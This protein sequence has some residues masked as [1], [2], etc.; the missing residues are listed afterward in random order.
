[1]TGTV[2]KPYAFREGRRHRSGIAPLLWR[3]S[4]GE[5]RT[6]ELTDIGI[7]LCYLSKMCEEGLLVKI[8][9]GRYRAALLKA[10]FQ[11][12]DRER[13]DHGA[14]AGK[15]S[16]IGGLEGRIGALPIDIEP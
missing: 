6:R 15:Q 9:Y 16:M 4:G 10:A 1:M 14:H 11:L 8:G 12:V 5:V 13:L 7:P 2:Q 3:E